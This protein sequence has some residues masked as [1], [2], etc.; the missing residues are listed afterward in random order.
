M[1]ILSID[2]GSGDIKVTL[3][4]DGKLDFKK[5]I[6]AVAKLPSDTLVGP[7][8][9]EDLVQLD[10]VNYYV[11]K[12]AIHMRKTSQFNT[13]SYEDIKAISPIIV[14]KWINAMPDF[15]F[16]A[17]DISL[18]YMTKAGELATHITNS[19]KLP[20][21]KV[22]IIP[23]GIGCKM[24]YQWKGMSIDGNTSAN[25]NS[26]FGVDIGFNSIDVFQVIN[27]NLTS[28]GV[29]G[30]EQAGIVRIAQGLIEFCK[31]AGISD[32]PVS[33]AKEAI[34]NKSL[35]VMGKPVEGIAEQIRTLKNRY[36][37]SVY[38]YLHDNYLD[39]IKVSQGLIFF[40]GGAEL[41]R[42]DL[43][44]NKEFGEGFIQVPEKPEYYNAL[45][46]IYYVLKREK[47]M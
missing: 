33:M 5:E 42:E 40:G 28:D 7:D 1:K 27:G 16:I 24:A 13:D 34:I 3:Y 38:K 19:L 12:S 22:V 46:N 15:D 35:T 21:E 36:V 23:Q 37:E 26:F 8:Q 11:G 32:I 4:T 44:S 10:G 17:F 18:A 29:A 20:A 45:G 43:I 31:N 39:I 6:N 2:V 47:V 9:S 41:V 25:V 14:K 30:V